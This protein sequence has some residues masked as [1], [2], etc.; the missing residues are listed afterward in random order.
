MPRESRVR[1]SAKGTN[2]AKT[3][4][5]TYLRRLERVQTVEEFWIAI[6]EIRDNQ[7]RIPRPSLPI[8][9]ELHDIILNY[10]NNL[11]ENKVNI[12]QRGH[13]VKEVKR[14]LYVA[15]EYLD[16]HFKE[17]LRVKRPYPFPKGAKKLP[18]RDEEVLNWLWHL[19]DYE[20]SIANHHHFPGLKLRKGNLSDEHGQQW[21][22]IIG[23]IDFRGMSADF[24]QEKP[25]SVNSCHQ[26]VARLARR[27][28]IHELG[29]VKLKKY[30]CLGYWLWYKEGENWKLSARRLTWPTV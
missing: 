11:L 6:E 13:V 22:M 17:E 2:R 23:G 4:I 26:A 24:S 7:P 19:K 20:W 15:K 1:K 29:T 12:Y 21:W 3:R 5:R 16:E 28:I 8:G 14:G 30:Y 18:G 9:L 10:T 27:G 25:F